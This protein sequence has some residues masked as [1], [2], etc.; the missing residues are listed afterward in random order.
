MQVTEIESLR[1]LLA[2]REAGMKDMQNAVQ[3][4]RGA[5]S[6]AERIVRSLQSELKRV[7]SEA[8]RLGTDIEHL[9]LERVEE[10]SN[11]ERQKRAREQAQIQMKALN[12][13]VLSAKDVVRQLQDRLKDHGNAL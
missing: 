9:K 6:D 5:Q 11:E 3:A 13:Q 12:D 1:M 2:E 10:N 8:E 4:A 7:K